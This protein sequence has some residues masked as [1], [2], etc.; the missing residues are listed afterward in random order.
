[1]LVV[2]FVAA[3]RILGGQPFAQYRTK[4]SHHGLREFNQYEQE[5]ELPNRESGLV[6]VADYG[7]FEASVYFF[8]L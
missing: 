3:A 4:L 5:D 1:M 6:H 8:P 7:S 2:G